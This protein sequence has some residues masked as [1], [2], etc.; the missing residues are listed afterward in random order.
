VL[1]GKPIIY[2]GEYFHSLDEKGRIT[3][4]GGLRHNISQ[5]VLDSAVH[6]VHVPGTRCISLYPE[7]KWNQI[8]DKWSHAENYRSTP[9]FMEIQ[10]LLFSSVEKIAIDKAGRVLLPQNLRDRL[11]L[12]KNV[13]ILGVYDK[14]EIWEENEYKT[15]LEEA[16]KRQEARIAAMLADGE[17]T[18]RPRFP[19]W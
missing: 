2:S 14:I 7:E 11:G 13:A 3:L 8:V 9:E 1:Q 5:S 18:G 16:A 17:D 6:A 15:Y 4:P 12:V 19:E 10:R